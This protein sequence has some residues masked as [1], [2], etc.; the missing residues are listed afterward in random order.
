MTNPSTLSVDQ[1][2]DRF[3]ALT[4]R[5][6]GQPVGF[7][8]GPGGTQVPSAVIDA[9]ADYLAHHNANTHWEYPTSHETDA[10]IA[11]A[12]QAMADLFGSRPDEIVFGANMTTLTFHL[13]RGLARAWESGDEIVVTALDHHGNVGPWEAVARDRGLVLQRIPFR[14]GDGTL[15][16]DRLLDALGPK[17]RLVAVGWA[18]NALGTVTDVAAICRETAARGIT[19]FVDGVHGVPHVFPDVARIGCDYLACSPYKFYGPH[20]GTL[21]GRKELLDRVDVPKLRPAPDAAPERLETGT[22]SHEGIVGARAAVDFMA[23]IAPREDR[24]QSLAAAYQVLHERGRALFG[25]LWE[26]LGAIPGVRRFGPGPDRPR[27]PTIGFVVEGVPSSSVARGLAERGL[28][29]SH[30]D[31]YAATVIERLG[32]GPEGLVRAGAACYTNDAE[33]ERLIEGVREIAAR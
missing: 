9:M 16:V 20:L 12:R 32:L 10:L 14:L 6:R 33:V 25:R 31:F 4:R 24:R 22:L 8:D 1:I 26:G 19:S 30:G 27:T 18:S 5:H 13:A 28:F 3:P 17:T 2:R 15:E 21:F 23:S 7:F 11:E 29:V